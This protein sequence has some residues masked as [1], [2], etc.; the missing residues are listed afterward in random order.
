MADPVQTTTFVARLDAIASRARELS[1][2]ARVLEVQLRDAA[3][4]ATDTSERASFSHA[5]EDAFLARHD[6]LNAHRRAHEAGTECAVVEAVA[7]LP[8]HATNDT[9]MD[10][11]AAAMNAR[12]L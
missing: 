1:I 4:K 9:Y 6:L 5:A 3:H 11:V 8:P 12:E 7:A 2:D 10:A